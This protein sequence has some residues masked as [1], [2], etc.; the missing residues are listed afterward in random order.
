MACCNGVCARYRSSKLEESRLRYAFGDKWCCYCSVFIKWGGRE[1]PC[2]RTRLRTK[3]VKR[4]TS[5]AY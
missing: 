2:C 5:A 4:S 1:C 3:P